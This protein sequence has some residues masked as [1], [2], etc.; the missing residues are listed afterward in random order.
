LP[1]DEALIKQQ[2]PYYLARL[3]ADR[4]MAA[5]QEWFGRQL[6][7][8]LVPIPTEKTGTG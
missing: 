6:Q 3:R 1:V 2:L 8:H 7:L 4:Q 5:F